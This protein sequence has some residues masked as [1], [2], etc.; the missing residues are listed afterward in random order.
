[1]AKGRTFAPQTNALLCFAE[2]LAPD[3]IPESATQRTNFPQETFYSILKK[4]LL[5]FEVLR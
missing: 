5:L 3:R 1:M 2:A 4:Q